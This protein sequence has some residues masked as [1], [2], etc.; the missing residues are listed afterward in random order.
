MCAKGFLRLVVFAIFIGCIGCKE[1][2]RYQCMN[3]DPSAY[4]I[5]KVCSS[6][7]TTEKEVCTDLHSLKDYFGWHP[8]TPNVNCDTIQKYI[9]RRLCLEDSIVTKYFRGHSEVIYN[10][11]IDS[12]LKISFKTFED[13]YVD[14]NTTLIV[15]SLNFGYMVKRVEE[16]GYFIVWSDYDGNYFLK[17]MN[18]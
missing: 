10:K 17:K 8:L 2:N 11:T 12:L 13:K 5:I 6:S 7:S 16:F 18:P 3:G 14:K 4:V 1:S 15:D 9:D